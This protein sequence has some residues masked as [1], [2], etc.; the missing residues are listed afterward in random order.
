MV[1]LVLDCQLSEFLEPVR[2]LTVLPVLTCVAVVISVLDSLL[3]ALQ[4]FV[5]KRLYQNS[6]LMVR[7]FPLPLQWLPV[8]VPY[9]DQQ[10]LL[11]YFWL[12]VP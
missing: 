9:L 3:G 4:R 8:L 11:L 7:F 6:M 12:W 2:L 10:A 1:S 5:L